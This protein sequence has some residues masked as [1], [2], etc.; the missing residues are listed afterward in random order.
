MRTIAVLTRCCFYNTNVLFIPR[1]INDG[2]NILDCR[3][4]NYDDDDD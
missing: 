4:L 2:L 3:A 1:L